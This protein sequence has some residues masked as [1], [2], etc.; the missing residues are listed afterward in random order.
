MPFENL[1]GD[2]GAEYLSD[3]ITESIINNLSQLPRLRVMARSTVFRYKGRNVD[4]QEVGDDLSV[5]AVLTGRVLQMKDSL[6]IGAELVRVSDGSQ[7]WGQ[8][9]NRSAGDIFAVQEE[10]ANQISEKLQ[11]QSSSEERKRLA[12]RPTQSAEAYQLY[13]KGRYFWNKRTPEGFQKALGWFDQATKTDP[14][15]ALAHS[16]L[17]DCSTLLNLYSLA[18]PQITMAHAKSAVEKAMKADEALAEVHSSTA[19]VAFWYDWD[20]LRAEIEFERAIKLNPSYASAHEFYGWYLAAIGEAGR[21]VD[22]GRLAIELDPLEPAV[23]LA[24]A[25]SFYFARQY[26]EAIELCRRA[27][28]LGSE[29]VPARFFLGQ[30]FLQQGLFREA[31]VEYDQGLNALGKSAFGTAVI[32]HARALGGD[33]PAAEEALQDLLAAAKRGKEYVP[34]FGIAIVQAGLGKTEDTLNWLERAWDERS[35]WMVYLRVDPVFDSI[36]SEP[37]FQRLVDRLQLPAKKTV[38]SEE[39]P[40]SG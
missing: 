37:R 12:K 2:V 20:W 32:A 30:S 22:E 8:H 40:R 29:F 21:S 1:T 36:R 6:A 18:P 25:K 11:M 39:K 4:P 13:L 28:S 23:N 16:G 26:D 7:L 3:G 15:Y 34:A 10:I 14:D 35:V 24:L 33:K 19:M 9:F 17:A 27:L 38:S 5:H 31:L